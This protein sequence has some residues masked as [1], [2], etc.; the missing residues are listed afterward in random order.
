MAVGY[1][2]HDVSDDDRRI[3]Y[4]TLETI[5]TNLCTIS[6]SGVPDGTND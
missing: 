1:A 5:Y 4:D 6:R 3:F 2:S